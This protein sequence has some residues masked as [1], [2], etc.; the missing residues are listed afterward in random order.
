MRIGQR[1]NRMKILPPKIDTP[2]AVCYNAL[3]R[4]FRAGAICWK[5]RSKADFP[6]R[7]QRDRNK[8]R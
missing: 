4:V 8:G 3:C 5:L 1:Q 6:A 7:E 2:C